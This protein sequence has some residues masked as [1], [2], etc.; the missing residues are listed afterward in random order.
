MK[1]RI[2]IPVFTW[3]LIG[4]LLFSVFTFLLG[5]WVCAN[6]PR[7]DQSL[8]EP[9][10]II[11]DSGTAVMETTAESSTY[12]P[13]DADLPD[14]MADLEP[15]ESN[16]Q[17]TVTKTTTQATAPPVSTTTAKK[18]TKPVEVKTEP[19]TTAT[20]KTYYIQLTAT[21]IEKAAKDMK[22]KFERKGYNVY[23]LEVMNKGQKLY[24]VRI[25]VFSSRD[26]ARSIAEKIRK[27][28]KIKPW[29]V[30]M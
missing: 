22:Q 29:I 17:E 23:L 3:F 25:G 9:V 1:D 15:V 14:P 11:N 28:E 6:A 21:P 27:E 16:R 26:Q 30:A 7:D 13:E 4:A 20:G 12:E 18:A 8:G 19:A 24:K 2:D 5:I 10:P